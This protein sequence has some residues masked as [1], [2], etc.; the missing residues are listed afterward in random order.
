MRTAIFSRQLVLGECLSSL[1]LPSFAYDTKEED[2][3]IFL[4]NKI[5]VAANRIEVPFTNFYFPSTTGL[6]F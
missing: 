4:A 2:D 6:G 3:C 5:E 1:T